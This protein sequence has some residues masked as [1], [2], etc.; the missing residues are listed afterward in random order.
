M[1][2]TQAARLTHKEMLEH[3]DMTVRGEAIASAAQLTGSRDI[4]DILRGADRIF[5]YLKRGEV[6][7]EVLPDS[8]TAEGRAEAERTGNVTPLAAID[9]T[10]G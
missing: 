4:D 3:R 5:A 6:P 1:A 2:K 8:L 10:R 9:R 7:A